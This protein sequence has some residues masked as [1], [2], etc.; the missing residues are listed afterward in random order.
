MQELQK[1]FA[2]EQINAHPHIYII[3]IYMYACTCIQH[4]I[5]RCD[6]SERSSRRDVLCL[7][8][9]SLALWMWKAKVDKTKP[10]ISSARVLYCWE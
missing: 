8:R 5:L 4:V 6:G 3:Y 9:S 7:C 2:P 10:E 1:V